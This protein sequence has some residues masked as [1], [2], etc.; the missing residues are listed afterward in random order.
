MA[1]FLMLVN[2]VAVAMLLGW[3]GK[4]IDDHR[5]RMAEAAGV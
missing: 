1:L 2:A 5:A 3:S 4:L